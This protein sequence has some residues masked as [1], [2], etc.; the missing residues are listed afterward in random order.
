MLKI[1]KTASTVCILSK[2]HGSS[3]YRF[4]SIVKLRTILKKIQKHMSALQL[5]AGGVPVISNLG[6]W[7][8]I[9]LWWNKRIIWFITWLFCVLFKTRTLIRQCC[10]LGT[11]FHANIAANIWDICSPRE[12]ANGASSDMLVIHKPAVFIFRNPVAE[13]LLHGI[14]WSYYSLFHP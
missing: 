10:I 4:F 6:P 14:T 9:H 1:L 13:E 2:H 8:K 11:G 12:T 7:K 5:R 3:G